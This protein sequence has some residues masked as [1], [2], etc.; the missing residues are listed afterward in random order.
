MGRQADLVLFII[1]GAL[2]DMF[3]GDQTGA[4]SPLGEEYVKT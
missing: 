3:E 4:Q 2:F 1:Q